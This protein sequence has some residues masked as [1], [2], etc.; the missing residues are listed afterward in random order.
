MSK[1]L[2]LMRRLG[3]DA[4]LA[5]E[6]SKDPEAVMQRAGLTAEETQAMLDKDYTT[7]KRITGLQDGKFATNHIVRCYEE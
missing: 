5:V 1:L 3:S 4:A 7:I 6:Y 2:D